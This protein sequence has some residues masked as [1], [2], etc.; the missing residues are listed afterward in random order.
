VEFRRS[1]AL[2]SGYA[3][4][5]L[6]YALYLSGM[7]RSDEAIREI[8]RAHDLDPLSLIVNTEVGRVLELARRDDQ[9]REAYRRTV[10]ID[11]TYWA[12]N[13]LI[14]LFQIRE[15]QFDSAS[16]VVAR[17]VRGSKESDVLELRGYAYA[18]QGDTAAAERTLAELQRIA[19]T[20][21]VSPFSVAR[22]Y[23]A[24]GDRT[25]AMRWLERGYAEH[26]SEMVTI[27][28]D[29]VLDALRSDTRFTQLMK[30]MRL[31]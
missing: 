29:P 10:E 28:V 24:L 8:S 21:Y 2:D 5:R 27:K 17:M 16:A 26:A 31:E 18:T 12:A 7:G 11:S 20:R 9:A 3:Q 6:W 1:I 19:T 25:R 23:I 4:V 22:I 14:A 15:R 30:R 13:Y